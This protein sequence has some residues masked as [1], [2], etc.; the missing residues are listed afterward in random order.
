[1]GD[2][3]GGSSCVPAQAVLLRRWKGRADCAP[4]TRVPMGATA[5][6]RAAPADLDRLER[7]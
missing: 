4:P 3:D 1:M 5:L 6:V 7:C 2:L